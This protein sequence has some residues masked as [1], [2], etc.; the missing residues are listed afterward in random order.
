MEDAEIELRM[1][2]EAWSEHGFLA[3][4]SSLHDVLDEDAR[5]LSV[6][7]IDS[8]AIADRL[9]GLLTAA[10]GSDWSRPIRTDDHEVEIHRV[11]GFITCPWAPEQFQP[12]PHGYGGRP[13]ANRFRIVHIPSGSTLEGFELTVHTIGAHGFFGGPGTPFRI[14]PEPVA[15][16][17]ALL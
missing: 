16:L 9:G 5:R 11:R 14:N 17:L 15:R 4:G 10:R 1:Q 7:G 2:P 6:L 3:P 13:T 8:H 12:C